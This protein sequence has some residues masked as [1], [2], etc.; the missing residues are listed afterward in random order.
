[1]GSS[2]DSSVTSLSASRARA[3][4][5]RLLTAA[6][7]TSSISAV[8]AA[9]VPST[10]Q[11]ISTARWRGGS[12]WSPAI[13]ARRTRWR[14]ITTSAGSPPSSMARRSGTGS[15]HKNPGGV[16][17]G[18]R[19]RVC[20]WWPQPRRQR[21]PSSPLERR[22]AHVGG[23]PVQPRPHRRAPLRSARTPARLADRSPA[24]DPRRRA[25]IRSCGSNGRTAPAG[26]AT[27][28]LRIRRSSYQARPQEG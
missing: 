19:Q 21:S 27:S 5:S 7:E 10:S 25:P 4:C 2:K 14:A 22:E 3:R 13:R 26:G 17:L 28:P 8:S 16:G 24:P 15:S 1:M 18:G 9:V 20:R 6:T 12:N 23:D 11:K